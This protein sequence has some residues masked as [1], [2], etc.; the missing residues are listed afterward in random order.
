MKA[1]IRFSST[2]LIS[3]V[4][5][6][7]QTTSRLSGNKNRLINHD[8]LECKFMPTAE[9]E[10]FTSPIVY[11]PKT[12]YHPN[13]SS[14]CLWPVKHSSE[15]PAVKLARPILI[16]VIIIC[17]YPHTQFS[18]TL[19]HPIYYCLSSLQFLC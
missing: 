6:M 15:R 2:C 8:F 17:C 11:I 14:S 13:S 7:E 5:L 3:L 19:N 9:S 12:S 1:G 10:E 18:L 16:V 4:V